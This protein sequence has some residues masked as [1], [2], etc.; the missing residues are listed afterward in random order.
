M[1]LGGARRLTL[2][3]GVQTVEKAYAALAER[4]I[5][6]F[7]SL[8][9]VAADD[10]A[11]I[12]R[13]LGAVAGPVVDV[14]CGPGHLTAYLQSLGVQVTGI[15][16]VPEFI[17]HAKS[18]YPETPFELGSLATLDA[19]AL[20]FSGILAWYSLIH[21]P[22]DRVDAVLAD[23]RSAT[24]PDARLVVG[25]FVGDEISAFDHKVFTAYRWPVDEYARRL[26]RAG[27]VEVERLERPR[28]G[29]TRPHAAIAARA[30]YRVP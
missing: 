25:F 5:A 29:D 1:P 4:Y 23:L 26:T 15:D 13:H 11:L 6:L 21:L 30:A 16:P 10:L 22:P 8:E 12:R 2:S 17:S 27:F 3:S 7:G 9:S 24:A 19:P 28:D 14:G 20:G 18:A